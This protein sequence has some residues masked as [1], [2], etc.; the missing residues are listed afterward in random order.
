MA[1]NRM[2]LRCTCGDEYRIAKYYTTTGWYGEVEEPD[3]TKWLDAHTRCDSEAHSIMG[4]TH[5]KLEYEHSGGNDG[6]VQR[7]SDGACGQV[8]EE[9]GAAA[10]QPGTSHK[11]RGG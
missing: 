9:D 2:L 8:P 1:N 4:P 6:E 11:T 10:G 3:F 7:R 5:I